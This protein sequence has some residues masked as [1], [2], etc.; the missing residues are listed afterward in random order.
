VGRLRRAATRRAVQHPLSVNRPTYGDAD[1][2]RADVGVGVGVVAETVGVGVGV[3][4]GEGVRLG[5]VVAAGDRE[6]FGGRS[7]AVRAGAGVAGAVVVCDAPG[8]SAVASCGGLNH[9]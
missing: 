2:V 6:C 9:R 7:E 4:C 3:R 5:T 1:A 8:E